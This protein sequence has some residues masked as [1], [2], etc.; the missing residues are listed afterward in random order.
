LSRNKYIEDDFQWFPPV[1][2]VSAQDNINVD[3]VWNTAHKFKK[4]MGE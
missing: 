4:E 1:E 3:A 2:L